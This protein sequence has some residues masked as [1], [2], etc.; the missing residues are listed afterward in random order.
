MYVSHT[1]LLL[2]YSEILVE[3]RCF[4]P[5]QPV[6]AIPGRVSPLEFHQVIWYGETRVP[7]AWR[8]LPSQ[9]KTVCKH[10]SGYITQLN[11]TWPS[12]FN[13]IPMCDGRTDRRTDRTAIEVSRGAYSCAVLTHDND[14]QFFH[15]RVHYT[16]VR[17]ATSNCQ[18]SENARLQD[19]KG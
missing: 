18:L 1:I 2:R 3:N 19:I 12:R 14:F 11:S 5:N 10:E 8:C 15:N 17:A 9:F 6:L 16:S 4:F 13:T 7:T